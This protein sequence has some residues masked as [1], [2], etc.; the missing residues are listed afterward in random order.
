[1]FFTT[2][3][4]QMFEELE[5]VLIVKKKI[6]NKEKYSLPV[7]VKM[8][9]CSCEILV[10]LTEKYEKHLASRLLPNIRGHHKILQLVRLLIS[11][12]KRREPSIH[13]TNHSCDV[14]RY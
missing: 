5:N 8:R 10:I 14:Q 4:I 13:V 7:L 1:M 6:T 12:Y 3:G 2:S 11:S 9:G